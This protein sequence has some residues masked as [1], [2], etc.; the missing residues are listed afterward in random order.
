MLNIIEVKM[1]F[2]RFSLV[3]VLMI[4]VGIMF[5]SIWMKLGLFGIFIV[6]EEESFKLLLGENVDVISKFIEMVSVDVSM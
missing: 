4:L 1:I 6:F 2:N 3:N 5:N